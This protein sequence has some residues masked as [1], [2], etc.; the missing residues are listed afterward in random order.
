VVRAG[1]VPHHHGAPPA[2]RRRVFARGAA[3]LA[4]HGVG[5]RGD[6][7]VGKADG[8]GRRARIGLVRAEEE[9]RN[10]GEEVLGEEA[11]LKS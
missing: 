8:G 3:A 6:A 11:G 5:R 10:E 4:G 7:G 9:L 1:R 2:H